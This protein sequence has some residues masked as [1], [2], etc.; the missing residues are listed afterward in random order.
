M[1]LC[2]PSENTAVL[3]AVGAKDGYEESRGDANA[4]RARSAMA[5]GA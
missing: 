3:P 4:D 1:D 5:L 2:E